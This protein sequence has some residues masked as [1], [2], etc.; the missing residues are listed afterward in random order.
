MKKA[1]LIGV[2]YIHSPDNV[3]LDGCIDDV[4]SMKQ[5]LIQHLGYKEENIISL[6]DTDADNMPSGMNIYKKIQQIIVES[7]TIDEFFFHYSGHG[8]QLT[9]TNN[10]EIDGKDEFIVPCDYAKIGIITDDLL[11]FMINQIKCR[12]LM[13]FD[14][15]HS[16][17]IADLPYHFDV[18]N[19]GTIK[20][21]IQS[22]FN[23]PNKEIYKISGSRD[24]QVS[25]SM[26]DYISNKYRGACTHSFIDILTKYNFDITFKKLIIEMNTWMNEH[27]SA[28]C[29]TFSSSIENSL[30]YNFKTI[31]NAINNSSDEQDLVEAISSATAVYVAEISLLKEN[32]VTCTN[33]ITELQ[34]DKE[35]LQNDKEV[36]QNDKEVLQNDKEVLQNDK[37]VLQNDKEVLQ[38]DKEVLQNDKEVLQNDKEVLQ[39]DKEVLQNDKE[40]LQRAK[41]DVLKALLYTIQNFSK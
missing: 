2:N 12:T 28:Q 15:C 29:P 5:M 16:G 3:K 32:I 41:H 11:R 24:D 39:N 37:E 35:V 14:C 31:T 7:E 23:C 6:I 1:L 20:K 9:D 21:T 8:S 27:M 19:D 17:S 36:L 18:I 40:V 13:L 22:C 26:Y 25:L 4:Q 30:E 34:N 10:D 33:K 38:N